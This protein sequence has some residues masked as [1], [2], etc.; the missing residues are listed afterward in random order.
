MARPANRAAGVKTVV[1]GGGK[2]DIPQLAVRQLREIRLQIL[3][4]SE[5]ISAAHEVVNK[6][7]VEAPNFVWKLK[8]GE[9]EPIL[10]LSR[11][12]YDRLILH[13]VWIGLTRSLPDLTYDEFLDIPATDG[14]VFAAWLV[15]RDQSGIF[16]NPS[17]KS[18]TKGKKP[19]SGEA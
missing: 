11:D 12:D 2:Y 16:V 3:E 7:T 14:E 4:M 15:V 9:Q 10:T 5:K 17:D 1:L 19:A 6:G 8:E 18:D 13:V